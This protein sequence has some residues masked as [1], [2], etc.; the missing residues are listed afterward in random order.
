MR[1][2]TAKKRSERLQLYQLYRESGQTL[3]EFSRERGVTYWKA[4]SAVK[5]TETEGSQPFQELVVPS[6][7][8]GE[9][10]VTLRNNRELRIPEHFSEKRVRQLIELLETC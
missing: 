10:V 9:Y 8:S 1:K 2:E 6:G 5:R 4:K 7:I 3:S